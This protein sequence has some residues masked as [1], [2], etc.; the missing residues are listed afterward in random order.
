MPALEPDNVGCNAPIGVF[1]GCRP[2]NSEIAA[3]AS[4]PLVGVE[5]EKDARELGDV[6]KAELVQGVEPEWTLVLLPGIHSRP[7]R[8]TGAQ[9]KNQ[10][11]AKG[12]HPAPAIVPTDRTAFGESHLANG[13]KN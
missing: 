11:R 12:V 8:I 3:A 10:T 1:P 6:F 4:N 7:A 5:P 2:A 13:I 9:V